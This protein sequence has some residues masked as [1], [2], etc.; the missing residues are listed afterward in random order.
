MEIKI[1]KAVV[2][3]QGGSADMVFLDTELPPHM[4]KVSNQSPSLKF[5]VEAGKGIEYVRENFGIE[6]EVIRRS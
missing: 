4:P 3:L 1:K 2:L 5:E 6:P